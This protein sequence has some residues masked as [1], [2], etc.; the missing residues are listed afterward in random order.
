MLKS[1]NI[2]LKLSHF[3][4]LI[5]YF[6]FSSCSVSKQISK[7]ASTFLLQDSAISQGHIG[8][9]IYE[10]ATGKYWYNYQDEKYFVPASNTKLF[11]LYAGMKYLGDSLTAYKYFEDQNTITIDPA[12]DP[13]FLHPDFKNQKAFTFLKEKKKP[14]IILNNKW[15]ENALGFGW[16]WNDYTSS[17]MVERSPFPIYGN[18]IKW[19]QIKD[20]PA[21]SKQEG[22]LVYSEPDVNWKVNFSNDTGRNFFV[23]RSREDNVYEITFGKERKKEIE[24]PF[25]TKGVETAAGLLG[26]T[27]NI[28]ASITTLPVYGNFKTVHSQPV[29]SLF[30][31]MMHRSDN[32]FAEQ[33]LLMASNEKLGY[34]SDRKMIDTLLKTDLKDIPQKPRWVDGSGLSRYNLFTPADFIYI[35]QK[36]KNDFGLERLKVILPTG[37]TGTL[38]SLYKKDSGYIFAK[39]GTLSNH[40]ALSGFL[41]T[42]QNKLLIFSILA[43]NFTTAP[44]PIR[45]AI[46]KFLSNIRQRY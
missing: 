25:V 9:S 30:T 22:I 41:I 1:K 19:I 29:D 45:K 20:T 35:L 17:D 40:I 5:S 8:I 23:D 34:M 36:L 3:L 42:K 27:L 18:L 15:K 11:S 38:S 12:G 24:I 10:P 21:E 6:L 2:S 14:V 26:D 32:F 44:T 33:T 4:F 43:G 13:T 7:Q 16:S 39:T 28:P 46:E 37:G 31:I